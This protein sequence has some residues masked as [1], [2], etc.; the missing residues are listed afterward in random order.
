MGGGAPHKGDDGKVVGLLLAEVAPRNQLFPRQ[1]KM[2]PLAQGKRV[3]DKGLTAILVAK[4]PRSA[5]GHGKFMQGAP[6][7]PRDYPNRAMATGQIFPL[8]FLR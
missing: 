6:E 4:K 7:K 8:E 5:L 3:K 1:F 2:A